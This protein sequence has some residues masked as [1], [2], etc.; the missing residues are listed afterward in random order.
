MEVRTTGREGRAEVREKGS[1]KG[2]PEAESS[3]YGQGKTRKRE[4]SQFAVPTGMQ[5]T[6]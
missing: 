1:W 2:G 4:P 5:S 6:P 3:A